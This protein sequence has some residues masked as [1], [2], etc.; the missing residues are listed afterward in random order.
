MNYYIGEAAG[1]IWNTLTV[2]REMT[3][4]KLCNETGVKPDMINMAVGWLARENK[5]D[6]RQT[7]NITKVKML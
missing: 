2:H 6:I 1:K 3:T 4:S 5:V 7:R